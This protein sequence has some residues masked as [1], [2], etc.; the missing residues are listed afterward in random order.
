[1]TAH[2]GRWRI[3]EMDLWEKD[4][5]DLVAPGFIE[6]DS[7][8]S[9]SLGFIAVQAGIDWRESSR[10]ERSRVEFSWEGFDESDPVTGRGWAVVEDDGS[11]SGHI[12]FHLGD[13]S[14]F[15]GE[16]DT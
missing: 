7:D 10:H 8:H 15:R 4:D 9:G 14:G 3:V 5:I 12:Y 13:D 6:F 2:A 11:L 16:Q 1:M